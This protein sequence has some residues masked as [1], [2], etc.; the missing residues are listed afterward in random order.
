MEYLEAVNSDKHSFLDTQK[1]LCFEEILLPFVYHARNKLKTQASSQYELISELAHASLERSLLKWMASVCSFSME[2]EFSVFRASRES[3][4]VSRLKKVID[5]NSSCYYH[6]FI[7]DLLEG[8]LL[9]FFQK[10]PVLARLIATITDL[11]VDTTRE[12]ISR[13]ASD[14]SDIQ[15]TFQPEIELEK[16]IAVEPDLSD[17]HHSGHS[18]LALKFSSGLKLIYKPKDLSIEIAYVKL[19]AWL[20]EHGIPLPFK[21]F[22]V[23]NRSTYGWVECMEALACKDQQEYKRY[24]LRSGMLLCLV[25]VLDSTDLHNENIIASGEHPVL[26]D[27]ETLMHPRVREMEEPGA[28]KEAKYLARQRLWDSVLRTGLLPQWQFTLNGQAYDVSGLGGVSQLEESFKQKTEHGA[29]SFPL[30]GHVEEIIVGFRQMYLFLMEHRQALLAPDSPL[31]ALSTQKVRFVFRHT[32]TYALIL[33]QTLNSKFLRDGVERSIQID[34]LSKPMLMHDTKPSCWQL[35][36]VEKQALEQMDI[37]LFTAH[38]NSD[39]LIASPNQTIEQYFREPSFSSVVARLK[40]LNEQDLKQQIFFIQGS[41]Y[42]HI[43]KEAHALFVPDNSRLTLDGILPLTQEEMLHHSITVGLDIQKRGIYSA[44]GSVVWIAPQYIPKTECFQLL[45][46]RDDVYEGCG[47]VALFLAAL[48][49]VKNGSGFSD[50]TLGTLQSL[51]HDLQQST[52]A[53]INIITISGYVEIGSIIYTLTRV[54]QFLEEPPLLEEAKQAASLITLE[55]IT[56]DNRF[57]IISGT[58]GTILGSG[59]THLNSRLLI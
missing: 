16:V 7:M 4:L 32:K 18:V 58:A 59:Q 23:L 26:I 28:T 45:P 50:L 42:S 55:L 15:K 31:T 56:V 1:P 13:L 51:R 9:A 41:L 22:L 27:L 8:E 39:A 47:G 52:F 11:W 10:Y 43:N 3:T 48:D 30:N 36:K 49:K 20:N 46:I 35:L 12:F 33:Q 19:L 57:D 37:P 24:Y 6:D 40:Q 25:Y 53:H 21:L 5:N 34:I 2:F 17:R 54:S 14:W 44:D 38:S 29:N